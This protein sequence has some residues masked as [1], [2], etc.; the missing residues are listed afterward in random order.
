MKNNFIELDSKQAWLRL[1]IIFTMSVIGTAGM[2]SVVIIMPNIQNEFELDRAASTYPYVATMF[3]YGI[4]PGGEVTEIMPFF[5]AGV[6]HLIASAVLGFGGIYHSLAGPE[7]L[8]E[9]FPF[10]STDWRDKNQMTNSLGYHLIVLGVGAVA[11]SVN[12]CFIGGAYDTW[13]PGG[14]EV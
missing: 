8:E 1:I 2:W 14:G 3:G 11:W 7:K 12:W 5:Q 9:D 6:V 13:A 10:F 4:G